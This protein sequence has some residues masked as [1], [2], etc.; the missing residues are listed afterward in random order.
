MKKNKIRSSSYL[1]ASAVALFV[2]IFGIYFFSSDN[3]QRAMGGYLVSGVTNTS[4]TL[5]ASDT[6]IFG[7]SANLQYISIQNIGNYRVFCSF[8]ATST[9][10]S[11]TTI[12]LVDTGIVINPITSSSDTH[13][14][15]EDQNLL[16]KVMHCVSGV[17]TTWLSIL[18]Y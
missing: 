12:G 16:S 15:T 6:V 3:S 1:M 11:T 10:N 8:N 17:T 5:N 14:V 2:I 9:A 4:S 18:K 7:P 13:F